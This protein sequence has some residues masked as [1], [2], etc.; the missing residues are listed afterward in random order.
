M[1]SGRSL[2]DLVAE[3]RRQSSP[4]FKRDAIVAST[5][6]G[7]HSNGST[8]LAFGADAPAFALAP[9][10]SRQLGEH[11]GVPA[12]WWDALGAHIADWRTPHGQPLFD[13]TVNS[14]LAARPPD[15]RRLV[16][17]LDGRARAILSD[18]F[19]PID[20]GPVLAALLPWLQE[21]AAAGWIDP[22]Q[23]SMDVTD[24]NLYLR[25]VSTRLEGE[26]RV[27]QSVRAGV[28]IRNSEVGL[29]A[30]VVRPLLFTLACL[31]GAVVETEVQ[32]RAHI[33]AA[34]GGEDGNVW[35]WLSDEALAARSRA[36]VL[37]MRD[38]VQAAL[39]EAMFR[40]TLAQAQEAAGQRVAHPVAAV[41]WVA[42]RYGLAEQETSDVLNA[43]LDAGDRSV[44]DLSSAV[45]RIAQ[46]APTFDRSVELEHVG[47]RLLG[48]AESDARA[49][50]AAGEPRCRAR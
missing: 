18:R 35:E 9:L 49:L 44:W 42:D 25:L 8:A 23:A 26:V 10:A 11:L 1:Q 45:T 31:N 41:E 48:L 19:R 20:N 39:S 43:F 36:T 40:R 32:R 29:G 30:F 17:T 46:Q 5:A 24:R 38:V 28:E 12:R 21:Q 2:G 16:R 50:A 4:A 15:E 13:V 22:S 3:I 6:L 37:E 33:G 7:V 34:L 47:G 27:G 14:L